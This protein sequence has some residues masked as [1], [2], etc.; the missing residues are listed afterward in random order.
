MT[1][2]PPL[3]GIRVVEFAQLLAGPLAAMILAE[4]GAE[5]VKVEAVTGDPSRRL[6]SS[7]V[8]PDGGGNDA[9]SYEAVNRCKRSLAIN[10]KSEAG[11]SVAQRLAARADVIIQGFRPGVM[12]RLGLGSDELRRDNPGLIYA[13]VSAYGAH[14]PSAGRAGLDLTMQAESGIM[15]MTGFEDGPPTK[16]GFQVIDHAL[17]HILAQGIL[18]ALLSRERCGHGD[19]VQV[20]LMDVALNLQ[21]APFTEFLATGI[22]P[23]RA[24]NSAVMSAPADLFKTRDGYIA[25]SAYTDHHWRRLC[26]VI[27]AQHFVDDPRYAT[28]AERSKRRADLRSDIEARLA[29]LPTSAWLE[30]LLDAGLVAGVVKDYEEVAKTI[31]VDA[32]GLITTI[33]HEPNL[34]KGLRSPVRS[35]SADAHGA[36]KAPSLGEHSAEVLREVGYTAA[37]LNELLAAGLITTSPP[38]SEPRVTYAS[39]DHLSDRTPV[40]DHV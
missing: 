9:P 27:D 39:S 14:G 10:L 19:H 12:D 26:T 7:W 13:S 37:E 3:A 17:G 24:G 29:T 30:K 2:G 34:S 28:G 32:P 18:A 22:T 35:A 40:T 23:T 16:V 1:P 31:D 38:S 15:S 5:V 20:S 11:R 25:I 36:T 21:A 8:N 4:Y 33:G 6:L